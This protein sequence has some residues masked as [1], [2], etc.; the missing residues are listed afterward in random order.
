MAKDDVSTAWPALPYAAWKPTLDTLHMF[1]QVVG[2]VRLALAPPEP[3]WGQVPLYLT[4]R[5]LTTSAM[6]WEDGALDIEFDFV[7]HELVVRTSPGEVIRIALA[8]HSVAEFYA[9]VMAALEKFGVHVTV[10]S[11][12]REIPDPISF[13]QDTRA[14]YDAD[15]V[16]RYFGVLT[17]VARV[18]HEHRA[19]FRGRTSP[20]HFFW[21]TFDLAN[22][23]YSGAPASPPPGADSI[24]RGSY[25]VEQISCGFWPG[26]ERLPEAA[27]F[28]YGYPQPDRIDQAVVAPDAA[29][30]SPETGL[31]LLRYDD[32][33]RAPDPP[34]A[35]RTFLDSTYTA[36]ASL[37]GWS[38]GLVERRSAG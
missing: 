27:F 35:I 31:F 16:E 1:A 37:L 29:F 34:A 7:E 24:T 19:E 23:R 8:G 33:R 12:P 18:M 26:D 17:R 20:V 11:L 28:A 13:E 3:Q 36:C 6:P 2:K 32:V 5:G 14:D 22:T 10:W 4:A 15:A 21:G 30:W 25:D 9:E 38:P